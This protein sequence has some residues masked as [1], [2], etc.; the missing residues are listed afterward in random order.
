MLSGPTLA[1]AVAESCAHP[2]PG[3]SPVPRAPV[4]E[5]VA[6]S[7]RAPG[8]EALAR[9]RAHFRLP[10]LPSSTFGTRSV[11]HNPWLAE[12]HPELRI[13]RVHGLSVQL[14]VG[15]DFGRA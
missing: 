15:V 1:E 8:A 2:E 13:H 14:H 10:A 12:R 9:S 7:V 5:A 3:Q 11:T 6:G 4:A